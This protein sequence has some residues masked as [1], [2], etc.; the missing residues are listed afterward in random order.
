MKKKEEVI[1]YLKSKLDI[2]ILRPY[3]PMEL[4]TAYI[5]NHPNK[6]RQKLFGLSETL[7]GMMYQYLSDDKSEMNA[8]LYLREYYSRL[9][10]EIKTKEIEA[11]LMRDSEEAKRKRGRP[12]KHFVKVQKSKMK[13]ISTNTS[14]YDEA[15]QRFPLELLES[16]F[17]HIRPNI[18]DEKL[19]HGHQVFIGDGTSAKTVDNKELREYFMPKLDSNPQPLPILRIEGLINLYGGYLVDVDVSNYSDSEGRMLKKLY[20]SIPEETIILCDDLYSSYG[21]FAYSQSKHIYLITQGK[22]KRNEQILEQFSKTDMLVE[23]K[24]GQQPTWFSEEDNLPATQIVRRISFKDPDNPNKEAYL[25]TNLLD[26]NKYQSSDILALYFCRWDIELSF[27][28]IKTILNMEY[29]RNK[30]VTMVKKELLIYFI[31]YNILKIIVIKAMN[32][33]N[34]DF[35]SQ[36]AKVQSR[37]S[38]HTNTGAYI[39]KLGRSYARKSSGRIGQVHNTDKEKASKESERAEVGKIV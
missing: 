4:I 32:D 37:G 2:A 9:S 7:Q 19:W 28:E 38:I 21:H 12:I 27:R 34:I 36:R 25:Y 15:R 13:E 35:F 3:I 24:A 33:N 18:K 5:S 11:K 30:T 16:I 29:L 20:R 39:D 22:H 26:S 31:I 1:D 8:L 17:K 23:W 14:S 6:F 10:E